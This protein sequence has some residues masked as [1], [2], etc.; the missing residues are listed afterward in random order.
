MVATE[1][2]SRPQEANGL[3]LKMTYPQYK[4]PRDEPLFTRRDEKKFTIQTIQ[5][6][7]KQNTIK[8]QNITQITTAGPKVNY[9]PQKSNVSALK[10]LSPKTKKS[11]G[12]YPIPIIEEG[13]ELHSNR[14]IKYERKLHK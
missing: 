11:Q 3:A 12:G 5:E 9:R 8:S 14:S 7:M 13:N 1:V 10:H 6:N 2:N 4:K